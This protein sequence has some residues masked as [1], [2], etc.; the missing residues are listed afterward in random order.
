VLVGAGALKAAIRRGVAEFE[1]LGARRKVDT[2]GF[3]VVELP[4]TAD[5]SALWNAFVALLSHSGIEDLHPS[6]RPAALAFDY[7]SDIHNGGHELF[8]DSHDDSTVGATVVALRDLGAA[9]QAELLQVAASCRTSGVGSPAALADID[10]VV[11]DISP[12][13]RELLERLLRQRPNDYVVS[14][15]STVP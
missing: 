12:S 7:D 9:P 3:L 14:A 5:P 11:G 13:V 8:L 2:R 1:A 4:G 6:Q 15:S 10:A